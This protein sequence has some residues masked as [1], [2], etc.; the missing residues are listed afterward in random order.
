MDG[1]KEIMSEEAMSLTKSHI[2]HNIN[3]LQSIEEMAEKTE[4][5]TENDPNNKLNTTKR[6]KE[7]NKNIKEEKNVVKTIYGDRFEIQNTRLLG[8]GSFGEIYIASDLLLRNY[9]ALK[10]VCIILSYKINRIV[11]K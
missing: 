2:K 7:K 9:C 6:R 1:D 8:K 10:L 11:Q 3:G 4:T 5:V